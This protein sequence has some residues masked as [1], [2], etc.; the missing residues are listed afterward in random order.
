[1][2]KYKQRQRNI[3]DPK[4]SVPFKLSRGEDFIV[5]ILEYSVKKKWLRM[6]WWGFWKNWNGR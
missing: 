6:R 1:V 2:N 5:W 4:D 3:H